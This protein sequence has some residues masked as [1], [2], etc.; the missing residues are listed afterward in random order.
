MSSTFLPRSAV[1]DAA[2]FYFTYIDKVPQGNVLDLLVSSFDGTRELL[3][4][5]SSSDE[6]FT[7]ESGKWT[8]RD[9]LGHMVDTERVFGFRALHMARGSDGA[10]PSMDQEV[11]AR[12]AQ[13]SLRPVAE[14]L[15]EMAAIR[16]SHVAMFRSFDAEAWER[17]GT[18]SS[19]PFRVRAFP[20]ILVGHEL[21]HQLILAE[22]YLAR[23]R[24]A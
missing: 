15:D 2:P 4:D 23:L 12:K 9:V 22:R 18:A 24:R 6:N 5:L 17:V 1:G 16:R 19:Y 13:A 14:M 8:I 10:L 3:A 7:Y 21:H 11:W 20:F